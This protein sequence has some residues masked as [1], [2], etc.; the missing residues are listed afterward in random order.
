MSRGRDSVQITLRTL[1]NIPPT[2]KDLGIEE[3]IIENWSPGQ[4]L[5]FVTGPTGSGKTTLLARAAACWSSVRKV[6]ENC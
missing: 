4:G 5:I 6:A 3:K 2:M 1:P